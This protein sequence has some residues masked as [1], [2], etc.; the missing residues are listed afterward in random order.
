MLIHLAQ[1]V[2]WGE[3]EIGESAV[4]ERA[5]VSALTHTVIP[6]EKRSETPSQATS[7]TTGGQGPS[8]QPC[9]EIVGIQFTLEP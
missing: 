1:N 6:F 3:A 5:Q 8:I 2:A 9:G 4:I 7:R